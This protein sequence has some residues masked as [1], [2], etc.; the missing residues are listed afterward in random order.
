MS[1]FF[2][3]T[4]LLLL[5]FPRCAKAY[6]RSKRPR[7]TS[8]SKTSSAQPSMPSGDTQ[9]SKK[10]RRASGERTGTRRK[11]PFTIPELHR[12]QVSTSK[13]RQGLSESPVIIAR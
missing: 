10:M 3:V 9:T 4:L 5:L 13:S 8:S 12:T 1:H 11:S 6:N 7:R 2:H